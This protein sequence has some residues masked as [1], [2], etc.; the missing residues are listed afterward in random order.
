[1][2][3][4]SWMR[5]LPVLMVRRSS[6]DGL[7]SLAGSRRS[8]RVVGQASRV[9]GRAEP[10]EDRALLSTITVTSLADNTTAD[11]QVTLRE[12]IQAAQTDSAVDGSTADYGICE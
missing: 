6:R 5:A 4:T 8:Q 3:F 11:G 1:M 9:I 2:L 12:A 7:R 10:L